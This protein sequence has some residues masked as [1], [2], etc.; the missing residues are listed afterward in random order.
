MNPTQPI[1][2]LNIGNVVSA[3][4]RLFN[5]NRKSYW[6]VALRAVAWLMLMLVFIFVTIGLMVGG[7]MILAANANGGEENA[8]LGGLLLLIGVV[9]LFLGGIPLAVFCFAKAI[10]NETLITVNAYGHLTQQPELM[11]QTHQRLRKQTWTFW[12]AKFL[13]GLILYV[14]SFACSMV[15]QVIL[16]LVS[17]GGETF[18][19]I[20]GV[21]IFVVLLVQ[22]GLQFWLTIRLFVPEVILAIEPDV[23]NVSSIPRSWNLTQGNTLRI[24][25]VLLIAFLIT[26][27]L[28]VLTLIPAVLLALVL[29]PPSLWS[30]IAATSSAAAPPPALIMQMFV[31]LGIVFLVYILLAQL[32]HILVLPFWQTIKAVIYYDLRSRREGLGLSLDNGER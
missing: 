32:V 23:K 20:A 28:Y 3:G 13:A 26:C 2:P 27:P 5:D 15:Q 24:G 8:A 17:L 11:A 7:G 14:V 12:L 6:L 18:A 10:Y 29:L 16:P 1:R 21:L 22:Y 9:L 30:A 31:G 19:A 4:F 25:A